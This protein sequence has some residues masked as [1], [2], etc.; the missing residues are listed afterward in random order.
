MKAIRKKTTVKPLYPLLSAAVAL[1]LLA[2][3]AVNSTEPQ[4][5]ISPHF[6]GYSSKQP[7]NRSIYLNNEQVTAP[8]KKAPTPKKARGIGRRRWLYLPTL[9]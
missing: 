2:G 5:G 4:R 9:A 3:Y 8:I 7:N 1:W 6:I